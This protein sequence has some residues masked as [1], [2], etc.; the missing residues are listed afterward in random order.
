M[1]VEAAGLALGIRT[2]NAYRL[3]RTGQLTEGVPVLKVGHSYRV[4]TAAVRR[5]LQLDTD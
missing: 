3:A 5:V 2:S 4:P 1:T